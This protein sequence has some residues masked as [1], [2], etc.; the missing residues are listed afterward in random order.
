MGVAP[1]KA[2][3]GPSVST[4]F[5]VYNHGPILETV[6]G[7]T[8]NSGQRTIQ[9]SCHLA[10]VIIFISVLS[11]DEGLAVSASTDINPESKQTC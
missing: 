11:R 2:C 5:A 10:R 1:N 8:Y 7:I 3:S 6:Q 9:K 4:I